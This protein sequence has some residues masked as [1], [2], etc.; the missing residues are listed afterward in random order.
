[1]PTAYKPPLIYPGFIGR[2]IARQRVGILLTLLPAILPLASTLSG[3]I[4]WARSP[5]PPLLTYLALYAVLGIL[6]AIPTRSILR[7]MPDYDLEHYPVMVFCCAFPAWS[8]PVSLVGLGLF[9][10]LTCTAAWAVWLAMILGK[11]RALHFALMLGIPANVGA[12]AAWALLFP[13]LQEP[14]IAPAVLIWQLLHPFALA[15]ATELRLGDLEH[16]QTRC[17]RCGYPR[18]GLAPDAPC[19]E[20]GLG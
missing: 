14:I 1:M 7:K 10:P 18:E 16:A 6:T 13:I 3:E 12:M 20:C 8:I 11:R 15:I 19:P 17:N 2:A 5:N 9:S 4:A